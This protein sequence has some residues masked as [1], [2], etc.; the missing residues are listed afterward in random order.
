MNAQARSGSSNLRFFR[1]YT[2]FWARTARHDPWIAYS[3]PT[4]RFGG[5]R[6]QKASKMYWI[7][8]I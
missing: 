8:G 2:R 1:K 3:D 6:T 7:K 5:E 4:S